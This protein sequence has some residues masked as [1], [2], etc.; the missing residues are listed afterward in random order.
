MWTSLYAPRSD[1]EYAPVEQ[2][3]SILSASFLIALERQLFDYLGCKWSTAS[4]EVHDESK[5]VNNDISERDFSGLDRLLRIKGKLDFISGMILM[6]TNNKTGEALKQMS[7]KQ[8][9]E[10]NGVIPM[11]RK[12]LATKPPPS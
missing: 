1:E 7:P 4:K 2:I 11:A 8:L 3:I 10:F 9:K 5:T 12:S 6:Y